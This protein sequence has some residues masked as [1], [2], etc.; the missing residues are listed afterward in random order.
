VR[1]GPV[2]IIFILMSRPAIRAGR[3]L[4]VASQ[5]D[6]RQANYYR[7]ML[8]TREKSLNHQLAREDAKVTKAL[9]RHDSQDA[10]RLLML[11]RELRA[12]RHEVYRLMTALDFRF[13]PSVVGVNQAQ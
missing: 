6:S 4:D 1:Q 7:R 2:V 5:A 11:I 10:Q 9:S 13:P 3:A 8:R 12:E